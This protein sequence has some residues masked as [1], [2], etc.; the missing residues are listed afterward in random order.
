MTY[1]VRQNTR[2]GVQ[3]PQPGGAANLARGI[4]PV[5]VQPSQPGQ[6]GPEQGIFVRLPGANFAPAGAVAVDAIGDA[7][8]APGAN[9]VLVTVT[10]PSTFRFRMVGIGFGADDE[11]SLRFLT[12]SIRFS[13][14]PGPGYNVVSAAVGSI[15]QLAEIVVV[16]GSS[17]IVTVVGF[18]DPNA[19]LTYRYE[20]RVRGHFWSEQEA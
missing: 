11:V 8:I 10:V 6:Y 20:C 7:N 17:E 3:P 12:W 5:M 2:V 9:A 15:R 18:A 1:P 19:V 14:D 4:P 16:R 13:G